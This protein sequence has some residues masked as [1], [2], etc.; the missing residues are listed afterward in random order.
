[1]MTIASELYD[2]YRPIMPWVAYASIC[3]FVVM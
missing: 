3:W 2:L 1:M